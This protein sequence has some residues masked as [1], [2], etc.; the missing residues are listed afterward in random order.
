MS[1]PIPPEEAPLDTR[2]RGLSDRQRQCLALVAA[3]MTSSAIGARLGISGRTVDEHLSGACRT[4]GVR[5][6]MQ[7]V[8]ILASRIPSA[9]NP[10][11]ALP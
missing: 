9:R 11:S 4:L 2:L 5:T 7:A 6:R 1:T 8:A 3:G 10:R